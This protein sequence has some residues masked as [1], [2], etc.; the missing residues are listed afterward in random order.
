MQPIV[1]AGDLRLKPNHLIGECLPTH[2][3]VRC[4]YGFIRLTTLPVGNDAHEQLTFSEGAYGGVMRFLAVALATV[5]LCSCLPPDSPT[6]SEAAYLRSIRDADR[7]LV[8]VDDDVLL[9]SGWYVCVELD[10]GVGILELAERDERL[11]G[12]DFSF[13]TTLLLGAIGHLCP[14]NQN[15]GA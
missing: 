11:Y 9:E 14:E 8:S 7:L 6:A 2:I 4:R 12:V 13:T 5:A 15:A 3:D 10:Q 1:A